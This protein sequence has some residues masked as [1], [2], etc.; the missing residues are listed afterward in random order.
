MTP[1]ITG[2]GLLQKTAAHTTRAGCPAT[3]TCAS[4]PQHW[5]LPFFFT[6]QQK[7]SPHERYCQVSPAGG[8]LSPSVL[9]PQQIAAPSLA[10][11]P[12]EFVDPAD[13]IVI[14]SALVGT[15]V[16]PCE[17]PPQHTALPCPDPD[18]S[19]STPQECAIPQLTCKNATEEGAYA[20]LSYESA[21]PLLLKPQHT[22]E[23]LDWIA[24]LCPDPDSTAVNEPGGLSK[25]KS[26]SR[27]QQTTSPVP[28]VR[29][30]L[31]LVPAVIRAKGCPAG[32]SV[33]FPPLYP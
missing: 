14:G 20:G 31:C 1:V 18:P 28:V 12:H 3:R 26:A 29:A 24:Q 23:P 7:R 5:M 30:Q 13:T 2:I 21:C 8:V 15:K 17:L 33:S 11:T 25:R 4:S 27:P 19:S 32:T 6:P 22:A 16:W 9:P 10:R